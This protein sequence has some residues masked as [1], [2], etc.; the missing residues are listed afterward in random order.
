MTGGRLFKSIKA[1]PWQQNKSDDHYWIVHIYFWDII[2][3]WL[4]QHMSPAE[5]FH[6]FWLKIC[7]KLHHPIF[8]FF[9]V[10]LFW[11]FW[12]FSALAIDMLWYVRCI[13]AIVRD[14]HWILTDKCSDFVVIPSGTLWHQ[15]SI[16]S[17]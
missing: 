17:L 3:I 1:I 7:V 13:K 11:P 9:L 15:E 12:C 16:N 5:I 8:V 14:L 4:S 10:Y 2:N 6:V